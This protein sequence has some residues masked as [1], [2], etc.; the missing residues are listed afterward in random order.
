ML[1]RVGLTAVDEDSVC[2]DFKNLSASVVHRS[3]HVSCPSHVAAVLCIVAD[4]WRRAVSDAPPNAVALGIRYT[5]RLVIVAASAHFVID[6]DLGG[7]AH[8]ILQFCLCSC[9][10]SC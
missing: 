7:S 5:S 4:F 9:L 8:V 3:L 1:A 6:L 10:Y 2:H